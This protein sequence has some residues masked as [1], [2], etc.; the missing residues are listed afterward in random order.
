[1][2]IFEVSW[3]EVYV[4]HH[5]AFI[6]A[7]SP[8]AIEIELIDGPYQDEIVDHEY[9]RSG[10]YN[11][12]VVATRVDRLPDDEVLITLEEKEQEEE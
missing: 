1:M 7:S 2:A 12:E 11:E 9:T 8:E 6:E 5:H 4:K 3:H 10:F